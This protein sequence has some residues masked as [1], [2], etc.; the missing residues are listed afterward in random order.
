MFVAWSPNGV[1]TKYAI[2]I[3]QE[4][5]LAGLKWSQMVSTV[6]ACAQLRSCTTV[7]SA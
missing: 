2:E 5:K 7:N 6:L 4:K 3:G 1:S